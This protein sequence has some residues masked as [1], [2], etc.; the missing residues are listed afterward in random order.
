MKFPVEELGKRITEFQVAEDREGK[1]IGA[2]GLQI[3]ERQGRIHSEAYLDF[4]VADQLRP[5]LWE[6]LQS[7]ATN[8]GLLRIWSQEQAPFWTHCGLSKADEETIEKLPAAWRGGTNWLTLK[9]KDDLQSVLSADREFEVFMAS[10]R[11]RTQRALRHARVLKVIA[12]I[13]AVALFVVI[14]IGLFVVLRRNPQFLR[15]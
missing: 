5:L 7:V 8:P 6:R 14:L 9:L 3:T 4:A 15:H 1:P 12:T 11:E 2:I 13:I 10:E